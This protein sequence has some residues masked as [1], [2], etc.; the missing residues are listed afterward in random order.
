MELWY[1]KVHDVVSRS[2]VDKMTTMFSSIC[3]RRKI[4]EQMKEMPY[5]TISVGNL[6][7]WTL[8]PFPATLSF[9]GPEI[10]APERGVLLLGD[11]TY[12]QLNQKLQFLPC[13]FGLL[14]PLSQE[15]K[16]GIIVLGVGIDPEY[17][18]RELEFFSTVKVKRSIS[19]MSGVQEIL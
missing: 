4:L 1:L 19:S 10:I 9:S 2:E 18:A 13:H 5:W 8:L 3:I 6:S 16:K 7:P 11:T 14:M 17:R 15:T 12:V